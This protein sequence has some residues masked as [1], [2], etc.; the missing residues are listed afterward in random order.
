MVSGEFSE[1][2]FLVLWTQGISRV[3][4][5]KKVASWTVYSG[6]DFEDIENISN[7]EKYGGSSE[8]LEDYG[9]SW[10]PQDE[11][12]ISKHTNITSCS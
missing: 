1:F 10:M 5:E 4:D 9:R 11:L 3:R 2:P 7:P 8:K 12:R 6:S